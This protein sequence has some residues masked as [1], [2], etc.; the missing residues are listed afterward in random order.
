MRT[1]CAVLMSKM[2][3]FG[4]PGTLPTIRHNPGDLRHGPHCEHPGGP[5]HRNDVG[6]IDTDEHG[7]EDLERQLRIY[8]SEG[9]TLKGAIYTFL[10]VSPDAD[11]RGDADVDNNHRHTYLGFVASG[12]GVSPDTP[13]SQV[14]LIPA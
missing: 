6:T 5:L 7:W 11:E 8:A 4:R 3:G 2:E 9:L 12:L 1:K 13:M 14:L 10:G